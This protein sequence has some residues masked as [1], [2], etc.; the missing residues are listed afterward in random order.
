M[1]SQ[2][3]EENRTLEFGTLQS[4]NHRKACDDAELLSQAILL[5]QHQSEEM[6][7]YLRALLESWGCMVFAAAE[8]NEAERLLAD[9]PIQIAILP[10][11]V[12]GGAQNLTLWR[13]RML[14]DG[15]LLFD[16]QNIYLP[17]NPGTGATHGQLALLHAQSL[18][19]RHAVLRLLRSREA[20]T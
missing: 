2:I 19:M 1:H 4:K 3:S 17:G 12:S 11:A 8:K 5:V 18:R 16:D 15:S 14:K 6:R 13:Y 9:Y 10:A 7:L 20:A